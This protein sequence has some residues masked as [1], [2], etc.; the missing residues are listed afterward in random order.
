MKSVHGSMS[1]QAWKFEITSFSNKAG[2]IMGQYFII[3]NVTK[4]QS[5]KPAVARWK[6]G[7]WDMDLIMKSLGWDTTDRIIACGDRGGIIDYT[8]TDGSSLL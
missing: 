3:Y 6:Q 8:E 5:L 7:E 2:S 1:V 4:K